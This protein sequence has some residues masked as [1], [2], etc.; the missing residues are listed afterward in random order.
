MSRPGIARLISLYRYFAFNVP[1]LITAVSLALLLGIAA[2]HLWLL[3]AGYSLP[4]YF[5]AYLALL[6]AGALLAAVGIGARWVTG[7]REGSG[8]SRR[9]G[10]MAWALGSL[11]SLASIGMYL[12]SRTLGLPGLDVLTGRWDYPLG[13]F[14]MILAG[15]FVALH[16]SV[17]T[18]L[19]VAAPDRRGWRD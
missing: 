9:G 10:H 18:G 2:V 8:V 6:A 4:A 14:S 16:F 11:A 19:N 13:T 7:A 17:L 5:R 3:S 1:A 12:A 15:L